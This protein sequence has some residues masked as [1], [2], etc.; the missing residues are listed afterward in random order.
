MKHLNADRQAIDRVLRWLDFAP[1][2]PTQW[3]LWEKYADWLKE[4]AIVAG[5]L[6]PHESDRIWPRHLA[7]SLVFA[8][9][10]TKTKRPSRLIDVGSGVGLPGIPLAIL[11]P[12]THVTLLDRAGKRVDL[13]RRAVRRVGLSNVEVRQGDALSEPPHWEGAVFRA[14]FSPERACEVGQALLEAAGTAVIG[15]RGGDYRAD[16]AGTLVSD[17]TLRVVEVPA[18][19]LDG[20]ASL[21]IMGPSE[22]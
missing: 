8:C 16:P 2:R 13:A 11:W 6:G 22:N 18:E 14:V 10:W 20:R 5:G 15:L 12:E 17:R 3:D 4:E 9:G 7:D 21:L 19:V 1:V